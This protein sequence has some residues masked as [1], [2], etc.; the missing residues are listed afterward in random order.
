MRKYQSDAITQLLNLKQDIDEMKSFK[1]KAGIITN[2]CRKLS[3]LR[4]Y[5]LSEKN[6][7]LIVKEAKGLLSKI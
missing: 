2:I 1:G 6:V 3:H 4:K 7:G 5:S